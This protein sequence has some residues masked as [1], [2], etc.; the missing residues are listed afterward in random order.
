MYWLLAAFVKAFVYLFLAA[1]SSPI[2]PLTSRAPS[3]KWPPAVSSDPGSPA[4]SAATVA[5]VETIQ[6]MEQLVRDVSDIVAALN[7]TNDAKRAAEL[8]KRGAKLTK[9]IG[10]L[11][12]KSDCDC[13]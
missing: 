11:F 9:D 8:M 10:S 5:S 3:A 2:R 7:E 13:C 4:P 6:L 1:M 12:A